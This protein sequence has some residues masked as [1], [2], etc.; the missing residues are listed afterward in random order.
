MKKVIVYIVS[1]ALVVVLLFYLFMFIQFSKD[2]MLFLTKWAHFGT[3][4]NS[5]HL[6][7]GCPTFVRVNKK[8]REKVYISQFLITHQLWEVCHSEGF[9]SELKRYKCTPTATNT[10]NDCKIITYKTF[11]NEYELKHQNEITELNKQ[12][13][14]LQPKKDYLSK[15]RIKEL[16][17]AIHRGKIIYANTL[18]S[19][20]IKDSKLVSFGF[21]KEYID[22]ISSKSG[23]NC[24]L[25][26]DTELIQIRNTEQRKAPP[27]SLNIFYDCKEAFDQEFG[28]DFSAPVGAYYIWSE[29]RVFDIFSPGSEKAI[30]KTTT[31][32]CKSPNPKDF[33]NTPYVIA[34]KPRWKPDKPLRI[35]SLQKIDQAEGLEEGYLAEAERESGFR[36]VCEI[37]EQ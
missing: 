14:S 19:T 9:C 3:L 30:Q 13:G 36:V 8:S 28:L 20:T 16:K 11:F 2:G 29:A 23:Y 12:K 37:L 10:K 4:Y 24:R 26:Y 21:E 34:I 33:C 18:V 25:P 27:C 1:P 7:D 5:K 22:W 31:T 6:C 15:V 35:Y 17:Q 32:R